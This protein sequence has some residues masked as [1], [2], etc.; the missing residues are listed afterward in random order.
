MERPTTLTRR[1]FLRLSLVVSGMAILAGCAKNSED[2]KTIEVK[3]SINEKYDLLV[4]RTRTSLTEIKPERTTSGSE[5]Y[6]HGE[7]FKLI[8]HPV[9]T[10]KG[11]T[12]LRF[13]QSFLD[14]FYSTYSEPL[15][16]AAETQD[17]PE[18]EFIIGL[19]NAPFISPQSVELWN[20]EN[21][22]GVENIREFLPE[23]YRTPESFAEYQKQISS[24]WQE[25]QRYRFKCYKQGL[26]KTL[27]SNL[28]QPFKANSIKA[29]QFWLD[30]INRLIEISNPDPS[31]LPYLPLMAS[32]RAKAINGKTLVVLFLPIGEAINHPE[33]YNPLFTQDDFLEKRYNFLGSFSPNSEEYCALYNNQL[34]RLQ[35]EFNH[36]LAVDEC[37]IDERVIRYTQD[38][39]S[40]LQNFIEGETGTCGLAVL[41]EES[42]P[43]EIIGLQTI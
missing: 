6:R 1:E 40:K 35:H 12:T 26:E 8:V 30:D 14:S 25:I 3:N 13:S 39:T 32:I 37:E 11:T 42:V 15:K 43:K 9:N 36:I 5:I 7:E 21:Q 4:N 38:R 17:A 16:R 20:E 24:N 2:E 23:D 28:P 27:S 29:W 10:D 22:V 31:S 19:I 34:L 18:I 41:N 33:I